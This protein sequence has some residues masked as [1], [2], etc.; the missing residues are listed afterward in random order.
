MTENRQDDAP[1]I[2]R[3]LIGRVWVD[4]GQ[5][6]LTDPNYL[7]ELDPD[8]IES[9]IGPKLRAALLNDGMAVAFRTGLRT[10]SYPVYAHRF[11]NG[12]IQRIEILL[13][14]RD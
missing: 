8:L 5:L 7:E 3:E 4:S 11:E 12:A 9:T 1:K 2:Q 13:D 14:E 6:V 10:G